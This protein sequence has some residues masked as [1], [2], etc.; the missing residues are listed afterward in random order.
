MT[1]RGSKLEMEQSLSVGDWLTSDNGCFRAIMQDDGNFAIYQGTEASEEC[2][3]ASGVWPGSEKGPYS[4]VMQSDGHFVVYQKEH[5][6]IWASGVWPGAQKGP[7]VAIMQ[8]DGNFVVYQKKH[9]IWATNTRWELAQIELSNI[10]YDFDHVV[11]KDRPDLVNEVTRVLVNETDVEQE[12]TFSLEYEHTE[13][14]SWADGLDLNAGVE[15]TIRAGLPWIV[16]GKVGATGGGTYHHS[17]ERQRSTTKKYSASTSGKVP[18]HSR[19][20][21]NASLSTVQITLPYSAEAIYFLKNGKRLRGKL[22][23]GYQGTKAYQ[24][25]VFWSN[26]KEEI[27]PL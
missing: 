11:M 25:Q 10:S 14:D 16:K 8:N 2:I 27:V 15:L 9:P 20:T 4:A 1:N 5:H 17:S 7:Y 23:G 3:W 13:T 26:K 21:C 22:K 12:H 6:P 24:M 19:V 18:P